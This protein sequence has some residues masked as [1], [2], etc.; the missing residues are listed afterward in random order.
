MPKRKNKEKIRTGRF[1]KQ[2]YKWPTH[3]WIKSSTLP[4]EIQI[5]KRDTMFWGHLKGKVDTISLGSLRW[6]SWEGK[7]NIVKNKLATYLKISPSFWAY[8]SISKQYQEGTRVVEDDSYAIIWHVVVFGVKAERN[9]I[10]IYNKGLIKHTSFISLKM[11]K[12]F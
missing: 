7:L 5:L 11:M 10:K 3:V 4:C 9:N 8:N 1:Q 12:S 6:C 2:N